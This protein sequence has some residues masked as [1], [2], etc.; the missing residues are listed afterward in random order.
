MRSY[1]LCVK[2]P[3]GADNPPPDAACFPVARI[4]H[5]SWGG[6]SAPGF[7]AVFFQSG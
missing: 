5:K 3:G 7:I 4:L 6:P 2:S 1:L